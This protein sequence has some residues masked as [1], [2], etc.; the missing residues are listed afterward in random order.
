MQLF[1]DCTKSKITVFVTRLDKIKNSFKIVFYEETRKK[2][3]KSL[4]VNANL[5]PDKS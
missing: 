5:G 2:P 4:G 1:V 3:G